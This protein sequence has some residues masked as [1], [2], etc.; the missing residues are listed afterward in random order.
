MNNMKLLL[1]I[2]NIAIETELF[3]VMEQNGL[4]CFTKWPRVVGKGKTTGPKMDNDVW[5]GANASIFS[6]MPEEKAKKMLD[7][8]AK[9]RDEIGMYEGVKAFILNVEA[10]TGDF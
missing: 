9:L 8:I 1:V 7:A 4:E 10:M 5:P 2:Y 6:V 3:D